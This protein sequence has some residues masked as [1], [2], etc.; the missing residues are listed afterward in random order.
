MLCKYEGIKV[1]GFDADDTLWVNEPY[2][3]ENEYQLASLLSDYM[4]KEE[5]IRKL[6][7]IELG[8]IEAYGYGIKSFMLSMIQTA[9]EVS[10][11]NISTNKILEIIGLGK[12]MLAKNIELLDGVKKVLN[13][14]YGNFRLILV[15]K[16]DLL[17][18]ERKLRKSRLEKYFHHIEIV[19]DKHENSYKK[20]IKHL[21]IKPA[22]F[23]MVGNS[24]KSDIIPAINIGCQ[25]V[26]VPY[27]TTWVH[28][29]VENT[30]IDRALFT[31]IEKLT[32][33]PALL[34]K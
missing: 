7:Q 8:N 24:M 1:V 21:D 34:T 11:G 27:H 30:E 20:L 16:G 28:E 4:P 18:Q 3:R 26:F 31:E 32:D 33:L 2:Y 6:Y 12:D 23:L 15:T 19:S 22:E 17:D 25:A 10:E 13:Q 5:L 29:Y 9:I 14:L